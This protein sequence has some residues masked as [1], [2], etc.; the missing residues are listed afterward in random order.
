VKVPVASL[1]R[2]PVLPPD[3]IDP[4]Q[5]EALQDAMA[6]KGLAQPLVARTAEAGEKTEAQYLV[7]IGGRQLVAARNLCWSHIDVIIR[8]DLQDDEAVLLMAFDT[9][10]TAA[11]LTRLEDAWYY[12]RMEA[13]GMTQLSIAR[14]EGISVGTANMYIRVGRAITAARIASTD[15]DPVAVAKVPITR[16]KAIAALAGDQL[17]GQLRAAVSPNAAM[18]RIVRPNFVWQA[19]KNNG[20][21]AVASSADL[22][23][24]TSEERLEVIAHFGPFLLQA[25]RLEGV[26][27]PAAAAAMAELGDRHR[28]DMLTLRERHAEC[29]SRMSVRLAEVVVTR[30]TMH[31]I[32]ELAASAGRAA[33]GWWLNIIDRHWRRWVVW[34]GVRSIFE[35][36]RS[37]IEREPEQI[38]IQFEVNSRGRAA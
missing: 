30:R 6:A 33:V 18:D 17:D 11:R 22:E 32:P 27:D 25:R 24:W 15:L 21:R 28:Q 34:G 19:T 26:E 13:A 31:D 14:R 20:W 10:K 29:L 37:I 4:P 7:V 35:G 3:I 8:D 36:R 1:R 12:A 23:N 9:H 38:A 2:D 16:L 5:L